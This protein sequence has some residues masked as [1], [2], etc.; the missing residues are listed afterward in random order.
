MSDPFSTK[1][2]KLSDLEI[3]LGHRFK[4]RRLL[5][6]ALC[7]SSFA[8]EHKDTLPDLK[9]NERL[10]FLGDAVINLIVADLLMHSFPLQPEGTLSRLRARLVNANQLADLATTLD[11]G[12]FILLGKGEQLSGGRLKTSVLANAY[13]AVIAALYRDAGFQKTDAIIREHFKKPV[14]SVA[15][16][17]LAGDV[18]SELQEWVQN[19][20]NTPP[21]YRL[22]EESGP[23]H[24]KLFRV[25][26]EA[27]GHQQVGSG[28]RIKEAQKDAARKLLEQ[29]KTTESET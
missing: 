24:D 23:D 5:K 16:P 14:K 25:R 2:A 20:G 4:D 10:E 19:S 11:L 17:D 18:K 28:K 1:D 27:A 22:V 21:M 7:H 9:D 29:L 3:K 13:E 6:E 8:N 15:H 26:V 12:K